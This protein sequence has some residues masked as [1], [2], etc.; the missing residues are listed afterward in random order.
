MDIYSL[1]EKDHKKV[2]ELFKKLENTSQ[3]A[4]KQ[5]ELLFTELKM[6]LE[7]HSRLE[8]HLFYSALKN[9][10]ETHLRI[11]ESLEEHR[12]ADELLADLESMDKG[13]DMWTAK[14]KVLCD[15]VAHHIEEEENQVF[16]QARKVLSKDEAKHIGEAFELKKISAIGKQAA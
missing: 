11:L 9:K 12:I 7:I 10:R 3:R 14:L 2:K 4:F 15:N 13:T 8:E 6:D 16:P 5:R 1:L